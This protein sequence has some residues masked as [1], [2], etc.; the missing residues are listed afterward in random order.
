MTNKTWL[1]SCMDL[2]LWLELYELFTY[3][4]YHKDLFVE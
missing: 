1:V 2:I 3:T 4:K